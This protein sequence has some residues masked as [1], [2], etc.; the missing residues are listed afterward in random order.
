MLYPCG[1]F[2]RCDPENLPALPIL[3]LAAQ[4]AVWPLDWEDL[5]WATL[6]P[7]NPRDTARL[8][9]LVERFWRPQLQ[10]IEERGRSLA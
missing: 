6:H 7:L 3:R 5:L 9:L 4:E 10:K 8:R 2:R 1:L